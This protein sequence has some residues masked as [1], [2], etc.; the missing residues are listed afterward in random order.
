[1]NQP[2]ILTADPRLQRIAKGCVTRHHSHHYLG[3]AETQWGLFLKESP[4]RVKP[5]LYVYRVLLTGIHLMRS[6]EVEA[7]LVMLNTDFRLNHITDLVERKL[8]VMVTGSATPPQSIPSLACPARNTPP[9]AAGPA[10]APAPALGR[11]G[12]ARTPGWRCRPP[13]SP[14]WRR[15]GRKGGEDGFDRNRAVAGRGGGDTT[16][17][18]SRLMALGR[19]CGEEWREW[20]GSNP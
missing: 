7:N 20:R 6:G 3:F 13:E 15:C 4:R 10:G 12:R 14:G 19:F 5:L 18:E 9:T 16:A 2:N 11:N 8:A 17:E 1:M